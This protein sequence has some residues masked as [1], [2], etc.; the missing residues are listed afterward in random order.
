VI[1]TP[2]YLIFFHQIRNVKQTLR[3]KSH[4]NFIPEGRLCRGLKDDLDKAIPKSCSFCNL[5]FITPLELESH[6]IA[7][8]VYQHYNYE[9]NRFEMQRHKASCINVQQGGRRFIPNTELP[10]L[11]FED[12]S[13]LKGYVKQYSNFTSSSKHTSWLEFM[14][15]FKIHIRNMLFRNLRDLKCVKVQLNAHVNFIRMKNL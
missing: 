10:I 6:R 3:N 8:H 14:S 11:P 4:R 1:N 2:T 5:L 13:A 15:S 12:K 9:G 7:I